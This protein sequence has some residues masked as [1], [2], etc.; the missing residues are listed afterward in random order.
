M[1]DQER[2]IEIY[3][4]EIIAMIKMSEDLEYIVAVYSFARGYPDKTERDC[5]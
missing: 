2:K 5:E 3:K 1:T 4:R